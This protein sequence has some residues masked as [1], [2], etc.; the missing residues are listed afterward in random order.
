[1]K[2]ATRVR[3][4]EVTKRNEYNMIYSSAQNTHII[5]I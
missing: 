2:I 5:T 1:M 4:H 3:A